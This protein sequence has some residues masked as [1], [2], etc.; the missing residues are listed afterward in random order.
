MFKEGFDLQGLLRQQAAGGSQWRGYAQRLLDGAFLWPRPGGKD[1]NAHPPIHPV[2]SGDGL[3]G[4]EARLYELI[5][6]RFLACCSRD[7]QGQE[8]TVRVE[9]AGEEFSAYG[10]MVTEREWLDVYPYEKWNAKK[11][12]TFCTRAPP[13]RASVAP[14]PSR[15]IHRA[16][17]LAPL[18]RPGTCGLATRQTRV[19]SSCQARL[20]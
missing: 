19:S 12:P 7:A 10:L 20:R 14:H 9:L 6:R 17:D 2:R 4:D 16:P 8:T 1:D 18:D 5:A 15:R 11:I 13:H 3:A